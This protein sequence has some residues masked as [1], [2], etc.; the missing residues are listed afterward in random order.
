M[1]F[2]LRV[3]I[4]QGVPKDPN[5]TC[6]G[7]E[8]SACKLPYFGQ[9]KHYNI[10]ALFK[11]PAWLVNSKLQERAIMYTCC[12]SADVNWKKNLNWNHR[13]GKKSQVLFRNSCFNQL[14]ASD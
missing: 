11:A 14:E 12:V 10:K 3:V 9:T 4:V 8:I 7:V 2:K 6:R 13:D 1:N 5:F